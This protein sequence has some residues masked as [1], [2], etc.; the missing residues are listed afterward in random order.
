MTIAQLETAIKEVQLQHNIYGLECILMA[1][2]R[3]YKDELY[4]DKDYLLDLLAHCIDRVS[5]E[6]KNDN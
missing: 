5:K 4:I 1:V 2:A 3:S 6:E